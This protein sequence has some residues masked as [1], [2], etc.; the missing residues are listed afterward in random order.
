MRELDNTE[1]AEEDLARMLISRSDGALRAPTFDPSPRRWNRIGAL[2]S[3]MVA[4]ALVAAL[5]TAA[6]RMVDSQQVESGPAAAS[7]SA[8][9]LDARFGFIINVGGLMTAVRAENEATARLRIENRFPL[10]VT[11]DGRRIAYWTTAAGGA[12][13]HQLHV[14]DIP[15]GKDGVLVTLQTGRGA[16]SGFLVWSSDGTGIAFAVADPD[17]LYVGQFSPRLPQTST[18]EVVDAQQP[19]LPTRQVLQ[20]SGSWLRPVLWERTSGLLI[21][22]DEQP[23][24]ALGQRAVGAIYTVHERSGVVTKETPR[25][26]VDATTVVASPLLDRIAATAVTHDAIV[27]WPVVAAASMQALA[28]A[29][30]EQ[31]REVQFASMGTLLVGIGHRVEAWAGDGSRRVL[32]T[33]A[34][35]RFF[36][37][38]DGSAMF[39]PSADPNKPQ[40]RIIDLQSGSTATV[41]VSDAPISSLRVDAAP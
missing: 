39:V 1:L 32:V 6:N 4:I 3:V 21:A 12:L 5:A 23:Q 33:D 9:A 13:P 24:D 16:D 41:S 22:V 25:I 19:G 26:G 15:T 17:A 7:T 40:L 18:I 29:P 2:M 31:T 20:V 35:A 38:V 30:G 28:L 34:D 14:F 36:V 10:A 27:T 37:R 11:P 8:P